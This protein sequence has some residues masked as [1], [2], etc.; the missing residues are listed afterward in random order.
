MIV[1]HDPLNRVKVFVSYSRAD[2][3]F[4]D[5][6]VIGLDSLGFDPILDRHDIDAAENWK[7]R[8]GAL[9]L[10][11]DAVVFVLTETSAGSS[12]CAWEVEEAKKLGKRIIPVVPAAV[13]VGSPRSLADLNWIHFYAD[14]ATPGSG[15]L[16]GMAK[17]NRALRVDLG[18]IREQTRLSER[19]VEWLQDKA[20]DTLLRGGALRDADEWLNRAPKGA[21]V[22]L[23][24]RE[25]LIASADVERR[26][27]IFRKAQLEER[28]AAL[29]RAQEAAILAKQAAETEKAALELLAGVQRKFRWWSAAALIIG[30]VLAGGAITGGWYAWESQKLA[31]RQTLLAAQK[32]SDV[33][34]RAA[35]ELAATGT[36]DHRLLMALQADPAGNLVPVNLRRAEGNIQARAELASAYNLLRLR[37]KFSPHSDVITQAA[38]SHDGSEIVTASWDQSIAIS[39]SVTGKL[40]LRIKKDCGGFSSVALSQDNAV[41]AAGCYDGNLEIWDTKT[42]AHIRTISAHPKRVQAVAFGGKDT[43]ATSS[44]GTVHVWNTLSGEQLAIYGPHNEYGGVQSVSFSP[45][46][47][48]LAITIGNAV[49]LWNWRDGRRSKAIQ[50]HSALVYKV[51]FSPDGMRVLTA[52]LDKTAR[53]W[54]AET[55]AK[56]LS[57]DGHTSDVNSAAFSSDGSRIVTAS[58]DETARVWDART[59]KQLHLFNA[60]DSLVWASFSPNG[61]HIMGVGASI[62]IWNSSVEPAEDRSL[63]EE[64][65]VVGLDK[66]HGVLGWIEG[67]SARLV[68][69]GQEDR[70]IELTGHTD[71]VTDANFSTDARMIV[72]ASL[73]GTARVWDGNTGAPLVTLLGHADGVWS[74][75]FSPD[76]SKIVTGSS[77][78]TAR[79]WNTSTGK[80]MYTLSGAGGVVVFAEFS[81]DGKLIVSAGAQDLTAAIWNAGDGSLLQ[82]LSGH[83]ESVFTA[84]FSP[85]GRKIVTAS[86]DATIQVWD[87]A[88]G[89]SL[90]T[91]QGDNGWFLGAVFSPDAS[92]ILARS[93]EDV[94][95]WEPSTTTNMLRVAHDGRK[96]IEMGFLDQG[97][98]FFAAFDDG[99]VGVWNVPTTHRLAPS[100][101]Q[102][103]ACQKLSAIG[104]PL[105]FT[106]SETAK[107]PA[108]R[109]ERAD[110]VSGDL[111]S[112]CR[113][114]APSLPAISAH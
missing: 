85:D 20:E 21:A 49:Q 62:S 34:A 25:Y 50:G 76:G 69:L 42:G 32:T 109:G 87:T 54:D 99:Y 47:D 105:Y 89:L 8:L 70:T 60:R 107:Y 83:Q 23:L 71:F 22:P 18:W 75:R 9:I 63:G 103:L 64:G 84:S 88:T 2:V 39:N 81:L 19:A 17:L 29:K 56:L 33:I 59:G 65:L 97:R 5:Q 101:Q 74:A 37:L 28:E 55:G 79:V 104:A 41:V 1:G 102:S 14:P 15:M 110:P 86:R 35:R 44:D 114:F 78:K 82:T 13:S 3:A 92:L 100:D 16:D 72:T 46:G 68:S 48:R 38:L 45:Q 66:D 111:I 61:L 91:I 27:E 4:A 95:L 31:G 58:A 52:S 96:P 43:L 67:S 77:D 94:S 108:L 7:H 73:D 36:D 11:C 98:R 80:P 10:S 40:R 106:R 24:V 30:L 113:D 12:T 90:S 112:P 93:E 6:L 51:S 53:L 26:R 57:F